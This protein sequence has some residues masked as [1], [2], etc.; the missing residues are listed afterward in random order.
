MKDETCRLIERAFP[1]YEV[2]TLNDLDMQAHDEGRLAAIC[3]LPVKLYRQSL[4]EPRGIEIIGPSWQMCIP[5]EEIERTAD[6]DD[7]GRDIT[8]IEDH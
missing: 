2:L 3:E 5:L 4:P 8:I 6:S 7:L 1:G